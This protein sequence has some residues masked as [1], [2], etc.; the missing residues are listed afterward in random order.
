MT[1]ELDER[2]TTLV[3]VGL[4]RQGADFEKQVAR[5]IDKSRPPMEFEAESRRRVFVAPERW[6]TGSTA[7]P[8]SEHNHVL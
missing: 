5:F 8:A 2:W 7:L 4:W 3:N 6:R 1:W